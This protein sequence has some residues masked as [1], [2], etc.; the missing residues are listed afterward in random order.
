MVGVM[1]SNPEIDVLFCDKR[2][3]DEQGNVL[4]EM[5]YSCKY[6]HRKMIT[7]VSMFTPGNGD[8]CSGMCMAALLTAVDRALEI[9]P[10]ATLAHDFM[11]SSSASADG[12]LFFIPEVLVS[13]RVH[14]DS[15]TNASNL[16]RQKLRFY[17]QPIQ[18]RI[19]E[20]EALLA[21]VRKVSKTRKGEEKYLKTQI[22]IS[23][24][25]LKNLERRSILKAIY[26]LRYTRREFAYVYNLR[27]WAVDVLNLVG[28]YFS[29]Y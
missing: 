22:E 29:K 28:M 15:L 7:A 2:R 4:E 1:E 8:R 25:R 16:Y 14:C 6:K 5:V 11:L 17:T 21:R 18:Q 10:D 13:H 9:F 26:M 23:A 12:K 19:D 27:I 24:L 20:A 3:I